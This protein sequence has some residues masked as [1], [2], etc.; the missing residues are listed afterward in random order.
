MVGD[1]EETT[2]LFSG[3]VGSGGGMV[4]LVFQ[5]LPCHRLRQAKQSSLQ[6]SD[7]DRPNRL[8]DT[9]DTCSY[10]SGEIHPD[11]QL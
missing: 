8:S 1:T 9:S 3:G 5:Y 2:D 10:R 6:Q 7:P 11:L 4:C